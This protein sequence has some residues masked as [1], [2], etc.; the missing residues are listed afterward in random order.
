MVEYVGLQSEE[1]I[2]NF[3]EDKAICFTLDPTETELTTTSWKEDT[4]KQ[5]NLCELR[6]VYRDWSTYVRDDPL[7][8]IGI[9]ET[10]LEA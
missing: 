9:V 3:L 6:R 10:K 7:Y 1:E 4:L 5:M 2:T 8:N